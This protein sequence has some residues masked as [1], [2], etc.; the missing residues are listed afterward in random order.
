MKSKF[1][2]KSVAASQILFSAK[3]GD[4]ERLRR[5]AHTGFD[6]QV[7]DRHGM[8]AL[9]YAVQRNHI[10]IAGFLLNSGANL[11]LADRLKRR[12]LFL[13]CAI[14]NEQMANFLLDAKAQPDNS[15]SD[16]SST[17]PLVGACSGG[18]IEIVKRLI[19]AGADVASHNNAPLLVAC[20]EG[21]VG[22]IRFL[23][24][25]GAP[26]NRP[27]AEGLTP[28]FNVAAEGN[29]EVVKTL[30]EQGASMDAGPMG[31]PLHNAA[32]WGQFEV[33][34]M[35]LSYGAQPDVADED[36]YTP[37]HYARQNGHSK[38]AEFL[39]IR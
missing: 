28:L 14:G 21:H 18:Y 11:E 9:H 12:V 3:N 38:I 8:S 36:G 25:Q 39:A 13:A 6:L 26:V 16:L 2:L 1:P 23:I 5:I 37:Q 30:L 19:R 20:Q 7:V 27:S 22:V 29:L 17:C 24:Q 34:E 35:L 33:V 32:A 4:L 10:E 31:S 15:G